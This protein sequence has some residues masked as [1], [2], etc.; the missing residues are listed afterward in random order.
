MENITPNPNVPTQRIASL[1]FPK[2][3]NN[4]GIIPTSYKDSMDYYECLAWL[5]KYLEETV[6]PSV[7]QNAEAVQELQSLY[8]ELNNYVTHYFDNLDVQEEINEKLDD[9]AESGELVNI[10]AEFLNTN[11]IFCYDTLEDLK[12]SILINGNFARTL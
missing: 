1:K 11:P 2:I 9:M 6:I 7:N 4:L 8:I 10:I 12:D 5:C 3:I